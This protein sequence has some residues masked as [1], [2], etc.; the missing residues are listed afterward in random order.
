MSYSLSPFAEV[1]EP[2]SVTGDFRQG[3]ILFL[4]PFAEV[5]E[6]DS[7]TGDFKQGVIL[8][9][10]PFA[11]VQEPDSVTGDF[12]RVS[13]FLSPFAEV[14]EPDSVT[15]D[16]KQGVIPQSAGPQGNV[17]EPNFSGQLQLL[18]AFFLQVQHFGVHLETN[19]QNIY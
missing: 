19:T 11:E 15:G 4:S 12:R 17:Q 16:F 5:Q 6:P 1:Q 7:I 13:Y 10:S 18:K 14:Q 8:F 9:L 3:V 2:D